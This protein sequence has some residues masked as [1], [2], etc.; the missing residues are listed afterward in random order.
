MIAEYCT[1]G[2]LLAI[3]IIEEFR[4]VPIVR[5]NLDELSWFFDSK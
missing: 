4:F 3:S 2:M 1:F 5:G